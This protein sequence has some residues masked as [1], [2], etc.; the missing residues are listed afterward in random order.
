MS[1]G[2]W[3]LNP[4]PLEEQPVLI[5]TEPSL[6]PPFGL[7]VGSGYRLVRDGGGDDDNFGI[8]VLIPGVG[9]GAALDCLQQLTKICL[10]LWQGCDF[11]SCREFLQLCE[12]WDSGDFPEGT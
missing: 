6:Q 12:V 1:C 2:C 7:C 8:F 3:E 10:V 5:T 9:Y 4:G 11:T